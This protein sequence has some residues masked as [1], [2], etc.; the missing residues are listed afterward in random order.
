MSN[1]LECSGEPGEATVTVERAEAQVQRDNSVPR[2][3]TWAMIS[4]NI[5]TMNILVR[6]ILAMNILARNILSMNILAIGQKIKSSKDNTMP[7]QA[8]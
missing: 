6:N 4:I 2:Q 8:V 3:A 5:L 7:G 1:I